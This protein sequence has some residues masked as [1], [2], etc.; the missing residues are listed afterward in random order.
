MEKFDDL[1]SILQM[2]DTYPLDLN[3][4]ASAESL[5]ILTNGFDQGKKRLYFFNNPK[6]E[7]LEVITDNSEIRYIIA[8]NNDSELIDFFK[9]KKNIVYYDIKRGVFIPEITDNLKW[10]KSIINKI[11]EQD[12]PVLA[13]SA[14]KDELNKFT[15][16][17]E[18]VYAS[19]G[20][21]D[22]RETNR[23][24]KLLY[25]EYN[26]IKKKHLAHMIERHINCYYDLEVGVG[27]NGINFNAAKQEKKSI[28]PVR[29][30]DDNNH[31][32]NRDNN[33][34]DNNSLQEEAVDGYQTGEFSQDKLQSLHS[35]IKSQAKKYIHELSEIET[36]SADVYWAFLVLLEDYQQEI[37]EPLYAKNILSPEGLYIELRLSPWK[38]QIPSQFI[39]N[40]MRLHINQIINN[41]KLSN[42]SQIIEEIV[43]NR[44]IEN[45]Y[46]ILKK[47]AEFL[48]VNLPKLSA[49]RDL[50]YQDIISTPEVSTKKT[51]IIKNA[52]V[53]KKTIME[54]PEIPTKSESSPSISIAINYVKACIKKKE[55]V[56]HKKFF[57]NLNILENYLNEA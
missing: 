15:T 8:L 19:L 25:M 23:L 56:D 55:I 39:E 45:Q 40:L 31:K 22:Y 18:E 41:D 13:L 48:P 16:K 2:F 33:H 10:E 28:T 1:I 26:W 42:A 37:K 17:I 27:G 9:K 53:E 6:L 50:V 32:D 14:G 30:K 20:N 47:L 52:S 29:N 46:N 4:I 11:Q 35:P 21:P 51:Q 44:F 12:V 7:H 38:H 34:N 36:L 5:R 49:F 57:K 3:E 54:T 43:D 24:I